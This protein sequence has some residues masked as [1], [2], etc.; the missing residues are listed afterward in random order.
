MRAGLKKQGA[1]AIAVVTVVCAALAPAALAAV[2]GVTTNTPH[3]A[4]RAAILHPVS[5][6]A[7]S[8]TTGTTR[9]RSTPDSRPPA[10]CASHKPAAF[11]LSHDSCR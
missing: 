10:D 6:G 8:A 7:V 2:G 3:T 5:S 4:G 11:A 1:R 9:V